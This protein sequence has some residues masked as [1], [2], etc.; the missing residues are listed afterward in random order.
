MVLSIISVLA[1]ARLAPPLSDDDPLQTIESIASLPDDLLLD[2]DGLA[3]GVDSADELWA[4]AIA[5]GTKLMIAM[6]FSDKDAAALYTMGE[7]AE[8]PFE[9]DLYDKLREW[10]YNDNDEKLQKDA[11]LECRMDSSDGHRLGKA[12]ADLGVSTKSKGQ[13][14]DNVCFQINHYNGPA[15]KRDHEGNLPEKK[16]QKYEVCGKEYAA[17]GAELTMGANAAAGAIFAININSPAK[18]ARQLWRRSPQT[19]ELPHIRSIS[20]MAWA[21]WNRVGPPDIQDIKYL[22]V[23]M[24]IN[25]ETN[26]HVKR[27]MG[28]L[29]PSK[30]GPDG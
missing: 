15:M 20:D 4:K 28:T 5:R 27:I 22:F 3:T 8:S 21:V 13:G 10:G 30:E 19:E 6:K 17:T 24:V 1:T 12:F 7:S 25:K 2:W 26:Q 23:T 14:G 18:A 29:D 9:G 16:N 11:D